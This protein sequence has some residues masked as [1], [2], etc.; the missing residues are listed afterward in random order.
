MIGPF[1]YFSRFPRSFREKQVPRAEK[2]RFSKN[3][4]SL[5][6]IFQSTN[7]PNLNMIGPF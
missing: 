3:E 6:G 1:F 7:V 5:P 2:G 4:K